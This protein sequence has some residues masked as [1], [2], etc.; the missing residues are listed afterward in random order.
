MPGPA[1][2][3]ACHRA[4][5]HGTA[6]FTFHSAVPVLPVEHGC[7][8]G[9][10]RRAAV[11]DRVVS[12]RVMLRMCPCRVVSC[13]TFGKLYVQRRSLAGL[14]EPS[15][16]MAL[17]VER[18]SCRSGRECSA[19]ETMPL[20]YRKKA[21]RGLHQ[22]ASLLYVIVPASS[23]PETLWSHMGVEPACCQGFSSY[24]HL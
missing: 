15:M 2:A 17:V 12:R 22:P 10:T 6:R 5:W 11:P 8:L 9:T 23:W 14:M 18:R 24:C 1:R 3:L 4:R 21:C 13:D 20:C 19:C 7:T 16:R